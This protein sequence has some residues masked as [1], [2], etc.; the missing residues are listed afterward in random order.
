M[1]DG[2]QIIGLDEV[3]TKRNGS[4]D[5]A[6][7][8]DEIFELLSI[9]A[10][11]SGRPE[12]TI[13]AEI[14]S[15]KQVVQEGDV[16]LSKIVPHIRRAWVVKPTTHHRLIASGEWIVFRDS[17]F[18]PGYLRHLLTSDSFHRQ[19]MR[20]V[21]GI[22]GSLVRARPAEVAKIKVA[23]L[24]NKEQQHIAA[25]L[26]KADSL[27]R[28]RQKA[29]RLAD[30]FLRAVFIDMFGDPETNPKSFNKG[31][32]RDLVSSANY[33]TS[34]K[35]SEQTGKYPILRMNNIT[36]EGGWDFSSMKYVDL[37]ETS[38]H[39]YLTRKGDLLFNRTN[40]KELV[41]KTAVYTQDEPMAI[42]GYLV[43]VRMNGR[44]NAH[45][46]SGY[47]NSAHGKRTLE[48]RAKSIVGMAN[49]NAQEMQDIPLLLPPIELQNKF[50]GIVEA[51][52]ER[53]IKQHAFSREAKVLH[54]AL[55]EKF[56]SQIGEKVTEP[57]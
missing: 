31:T 44:G 40:S 38:A 39:K 7:F 49:I 6:K 41:G 27:R 52:Q 43:R 12:I 54:A 22:G 4:V 47:L 9:P 48:A 30:K 21:S 33:G 56:F 35:A 50:A 18:D 19:F 15:T 5:P 8:P 24:P 16:L 14:G 46:V 45:Y 36:Y 37:D 17:R 11:D 51:V 23:L 25:V 2:L 32:I 57:C 3:I 13:G 55:S 10:F 29:I 1:T 26:D 28:K 42:A 53:L 20:T 34:E